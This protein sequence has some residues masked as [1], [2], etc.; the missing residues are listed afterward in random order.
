[1]RVK[2]RKQ[3]NEKKQ[4][5]KIIYLKYYPASKQNIRQKKNRNNKN[6]PNRKNL[7]PNNYLIK[8]AIIVKNKPCPKKSQKRQIPIRNSN[9][10]RRPPQE[11]LNKKVAFSLDIT[12]RAIN[13][14]CLTAPPQKKMQK[15]RL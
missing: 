11:T 8:K 1:M 7:N 14:Q 6:Y 10:Q 15:E 12:T 2:T 4:K 3:E 9:R 5:Q 13:A